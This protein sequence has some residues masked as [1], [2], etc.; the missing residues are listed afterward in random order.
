MSDLNGRYPRNEPGLGI[1]CLETLLVQ[2]REDSRDLKRLWNA[3][4]KEPRNESRIEEVVKSLG[5]LKEGVRSYRELMKAG[6]EG[7]SCKDVMDIEQDVC[8]KEQKMKELLFALAMEIHHPA[9]SRGVSEC[10]TE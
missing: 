3:F 9:A 4:E 7:V 6:I 10:K 1:R 2:L 8:V 5:W